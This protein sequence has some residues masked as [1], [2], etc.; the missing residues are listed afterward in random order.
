MENWRKN[1]E[2]GVVENRTPNEM[3]EYV[4]VGLANQFHDDNGNLTNDGVRGY[5]WDYKNRLHQ[6]CLLDPNNPKGVDGIPGTSDDCQAPAAAQIATYSYDAMNRRIRKVVTNSGSLNGTTDF[7]YDGLRTIEERNGANVV[8][9]Q[10]VY[11]IYLDEAL[12]LDRNLNGD[13]TTIGPG[14]QRLFYHQNTQYSVHALTNPTGTIVEAYQYDAYGRA[15]VFTAQG[16]DGVWFTNDDSQALASA[17]KNPYTY[18]GQRLD[19]ETLLMYFKARYFDTGLGRFISR[20]PIGYVDGMNLYNGY[21]VP[22][23]VDPMGLSCTVEIDIILITTSLDTNRG[24]KTVPVGPK[25]GSFWK[26]RL[27]TLGEIDVPGEDTSGLIDVILKEAGDCCIETLNIYAHNGSAGVYFGDYFQFQPLG[28]TEEELAQLS[29][30]KGKYCDDSNVYFMQCGPG[31]AYD[32][33]EAH[34]RYLTLKMFA[35]LWNTNVWGP[36]TYLD[37]VTG[38]TEDG[39]WLGAAAGTGTFMTMSP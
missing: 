20:D 10:Y 39:I 38:P 14:D 2:N 30:L 5:R 33:E 7:N 8:V 37:P 29:K 19:S 22:S 6:V 23:G 28:F 12:V 26:A 27:F 36:S 1:I 16:S 21:F 17:I 24:G 3:N 34:Q 13:A 18:T 35:E 25:G 32:P 9:Q 4:T 11:G 15:T 31:E